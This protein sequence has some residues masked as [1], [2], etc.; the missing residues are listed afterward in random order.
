MYSYHKNLLPQCFSNLY[1]VA[2]ERHNYSTRFA[3]KSSLR[4][5]SVKTNYGKFNIR[6]A[7]AKAWNAIDQDMKKA[8]SISQLE[9]NNNNNNNNSLYLCMVKTINGSYIADV[10]VSYNYQI[11]T[12]CLFDYLS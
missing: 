5:P 12:I 3:S 11:T 8:S 2:N 10:A 6:F 1:V 7:G 9:S 4:L